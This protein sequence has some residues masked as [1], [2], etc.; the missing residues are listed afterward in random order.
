MFNRGTN[1]EGTTVGYA[2]I[3]SICGSGS[4]SVVQVSSRISNT[5]PLTGL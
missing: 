1:F 5:S 2:Q 4:A 3:R